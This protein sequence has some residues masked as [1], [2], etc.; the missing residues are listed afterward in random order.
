MTDYGLHVYDADGNTVFEFNDNLGRIFWFKL[1]SPQ[2]SGQAVVADVFKYGV[3]NIFASGFI[4]F[5]DD[6]WSVLGTRGTPESA[7]IVDTRRIGS[8]LL[9][10]WQPTPLEGNSSFIS[11]GPSD[12]SIIF[13]YGY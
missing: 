1:V 3:P 7:H 10:E 6:E 11:D 8:N 5:T 9:I 12:W 2:E 4:I 13:V